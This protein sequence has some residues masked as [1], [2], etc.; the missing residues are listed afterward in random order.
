MSSPLPDEEGARA[1]VTD[2]SA[3]MRIYGDIQSGNCYKIRLLLAYLGRDP[4]RD[5]E[6]IHL[7]IMAG[8][9]RTT[10]FLARN[11]NGRIPVLELDDG[12]YLSESTAI[13][14]YLAADTP[15]LPDEPY[16]RAEVLKW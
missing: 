16:A 4:G 14:N 12:R 3:E 10:E 15:Y 13:L 11:P 1:K 9:T 2:H 5:Y 7:D 6:W 8:E